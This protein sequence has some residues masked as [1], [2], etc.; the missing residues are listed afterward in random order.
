[1]SVLA[2]VEEIDAVVTDAEVEQFGHPLTWDE[3]VA[4]AAA[5]RKKREES[6]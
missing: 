5:R 4:I 1:M 2:D 6:S 3:R